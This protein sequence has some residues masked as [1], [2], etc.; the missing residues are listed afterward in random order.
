MST[1]FGFFIGEPMKSILVKT[2]IILS[3]FVSYNCTSLLH[4]TGLLW[5]RAY[6][7]I[8]SNVVI[9]GDFVW[10]YSETGNQ[11]E[12]IL[13]IHGFG[14]DRDHWTR[15][16]RNF[17]PG[18]KVIAPD[19][20]GF[21]QNLKREGDSY[22]IS[23]QVKRLHEF[24]QTIG[25]KNFHIAGN[26]MGGHIAGVYAATY[27]KEV[28]SL[29]LIDNAGVK[30]PVPSDM[31]MMLERGE[32]NPLLVNSVED[33]DR[34]MAFSFV[35]PPYLPGFMKR[36]FAEKAIANRPWNEGIF[37]QMRSEGYLLESKLSEFKTKTLVIW[38][39]QDRVIHKSVTE[40]LKQKLKVQH[41]IE[42]MNG[43]GHAPMI[44]VPEE[45]AE[46]VINWIQ[47]LKK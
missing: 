30:S 36:H 10:H 32:P 33:F 7:D 14:G 8:E 28:K 27:P 13:A 31:A 40:V 38:G 41:R 45:T 12:V 46:L 42:I 43:V 24:V 21:G 2:S 39:E 37:Q 3:L 22:T 23:S 15:F 17:G 47:S 26:S 5:E 44:E 11:G 29:I 25:L 18:Y 35:K 34:L 19:L 4:K 6:S 16:A 9:V 20:P 1:S